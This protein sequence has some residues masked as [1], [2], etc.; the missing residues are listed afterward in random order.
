MGEEPTFD[1]IDKGDEILEGDTG[2]TLVVRR[3]FLMPRAN[4]DEWL[5]NI[6]QSTCTIEGKL[7]RFV[8]DAGSCENIVSTEAAQK[9][10]V[11]IET[12]P[13]PYKL[14]WLKKG[15]EVTIFKRALVI[16][17]IRSKYKDRVWCD[18]VTMDAYHLLLGRS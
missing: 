18:V 11:K 9:L 13:K 15:G 2:P 17:S 10:G 6:L 5:G 14:A 3:M 4:E 8:V 12:Y 1:G 7:C 16:F